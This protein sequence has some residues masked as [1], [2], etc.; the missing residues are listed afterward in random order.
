MN[1]ILMYKLIEQLVNSKKIKEITR[2]QLKNVD[3]NIEVCKMQIDLIKKNKW[4]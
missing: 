2:E 3:V 1:E 4:N